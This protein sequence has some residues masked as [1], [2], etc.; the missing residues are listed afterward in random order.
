M[1]MDSY[2][3]AKS[4]GFILERANQ[5]QWMSYCWIMMNPVHGRGSSA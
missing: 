4:D 1:H 3:Y 5:P 2:I